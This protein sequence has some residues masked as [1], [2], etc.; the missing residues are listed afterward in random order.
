[1]SINLI[2]L[3]I[4]MS[5]TVT[6]FA[7][8]ALRPYASSLGLVD[9]PGGHKQHSGDVPVI[10]GIAMFIGMFA[11][12]YLVKSDMMIFL[13]TLVAT[14]T[15]VAVGALDDR[16]TVPASFRMLAQLGAILVMIFGDNQR[17]LDIGD[18]FGT[19]I[20]FMGNYEIIFTVV[21]SLTV[22]NAFNMADGADG[23]A[24]SLAFVALIAIAI[25]CGP[26]SLFF[27]VSM[28][29]AAS[30][31][32]FLLFNYPG[33]LNQ[34]AKVFMGDA[35][36]TLLGF[37]IVWISIGV[38]GGAVKL[39]SPVH[40]LWFAAIPVFDCLTCFVRRSFQK[41]SPFSAG[42]DHFHHRLQA[43]GYSGRQ[44]LGVLVGL[45][46]SYAAIGVAGHYAGI[47]DHLMFA[48]W[49]ALGLSQSLIIS[50]IGGTVRFPRWTRRR[51]WDIPN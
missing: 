1:M 49:S 33:K 13:I 3:A 29:I 17:L 38:S 32:G 19:G 35:G 16:R 37:V 47:A 41:K 8:F 12:L 22:I 10:G 9:R 30:I 15:L 11:G 26:G 43:S 39:I 40:C 5:L 27:A 20:I 25:A 28:T 6:V 48:A 44:S 23:L 7:M 50:L 18:P 31:F 36:S 42:R 24:G 14:G 34:G 51:G 46:A 2:I 21:V 4:T 45:Q